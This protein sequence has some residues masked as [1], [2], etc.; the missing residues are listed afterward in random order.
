LQRSHSCLCGFG[1]E[2]ETRFQP[3]FQE[4]E[5]EPSRYLISLPDLAP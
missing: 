4:P 1:R 2:H 5:G 3:L